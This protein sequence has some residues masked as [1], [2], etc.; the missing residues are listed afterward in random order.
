MAHTLSSKQWLYIHPRANTKVVHSDQTS[1]NV[2]ITAY[3]QTSLRAVSHKQ[4]GEKREAHLE[5]KIRECMCDS[6][7]RLMAT[8]SVEQNGYARRRLA[9]VYRCNLEAGSSVD[10]RGETTSGR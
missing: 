8:A 7:F 1:T 2:T 4:G 9:I 5:C 3:M 6:G 10:D